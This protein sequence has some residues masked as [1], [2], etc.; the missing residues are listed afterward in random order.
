MRVT[1]ITFFKYRLIEAR[2]V[3]GE[4]LSDILPYRISLLVYQRWRL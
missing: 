2:A 4:V 1:R 3:F